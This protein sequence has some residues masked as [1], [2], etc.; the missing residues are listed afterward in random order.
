MRFIKIGNI[1]EKFGRGA[2][3]YYEFF[4]PE[5]TLLYRWSNENPRIPE[6]YR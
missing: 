6:D 1:I 3:N 2:V 4:M 5:H